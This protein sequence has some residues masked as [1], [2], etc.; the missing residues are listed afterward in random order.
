MTRIKGWLFITKLM[1]ATTQL[2][3]YRKPNVN[4]L[5][6]LLLGVSAQKALIDL[7]SPPPFVHLVA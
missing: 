4:L 7:L 3:V 5:I 1:K 2:Y 6:T